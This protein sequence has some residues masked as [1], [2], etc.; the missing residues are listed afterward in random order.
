MIQYYLFHRGI[1]LSAQKKALKFSARFFWFH[2]VLQFHSVSP[3]AYTSDLDFALCYLITLIFLYLSLNK[4]AE[5][6][7]EVYK[8]TNR[9]TRD[10]LCI[11]LKVWESKS[12]ESFFSAWPQIAS[13]MS[14]V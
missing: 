12:R 9:I 4:P 8:N 7:R 6:Y 2:L 3:R 5:R 14:S 1:K 10:C 13:G 11:G